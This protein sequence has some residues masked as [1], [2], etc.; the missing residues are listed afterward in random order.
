MGFRTHHGPALYISVVAEAARYS[1][2]GFV[3]NFHNLVRT[4]NSARNLH[5]GDP[6]RTRL[7]L[8]PE[9]ELTYDSD[10]PAA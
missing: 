7:T 8:A 9:H 3:V 6:P 4:R 1:P 10:Q 2:P 5:F